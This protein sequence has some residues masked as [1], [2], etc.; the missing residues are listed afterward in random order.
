MRN[1]L[2]HRGTSGGSGDH[3]DVGSSQMQVGTIPGGMSQSNQDSMIYKGGAKIINSK[4]VNAKESSGPGM[5]P[6]HHK[7]NSMQISSKHKA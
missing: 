1:Q 5:Q 2:S 3:N 6:G 4:I 7:A